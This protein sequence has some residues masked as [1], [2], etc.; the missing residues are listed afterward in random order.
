MV[1]NHIVR[2]CLVQSPSKLQDVCHKTQNVHNAQGSSP[3]FL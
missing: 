2:Q 1:E 3:V